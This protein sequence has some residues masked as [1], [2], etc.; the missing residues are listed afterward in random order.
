MGKEKLTM[1]FLTERG[2]VQIEDST[3]GASEYVGYQPSMTPVFEQWVSFPIHPI[4]TEDEFQFFLQQGARD[5]L[6]E[7][8]P[9]SREDY[10]Y[11]ESL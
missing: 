10:D 11:Y 8:G 3:A 5:I 1:N 4:W 9:I 6:K 2:V 7:I